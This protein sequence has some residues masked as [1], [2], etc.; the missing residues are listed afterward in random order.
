LLPDPIKDFQNQPEQCQKYIVEEAV[1]YWEALE[2][3]DHQHHHHDLHLCQLSY[4]RVIP[5]EEVLNNS[6]CERN[7][8]VHE[9]VK[10]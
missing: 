2:Y 10:H 4:R 8:E 3:E 7:K 9:V 6:Q 1:T 5:E